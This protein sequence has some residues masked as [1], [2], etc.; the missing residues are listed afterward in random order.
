MAYFFFSLAPLFGMLLCWSAS[1]SSQR[2]SPWAGDNR[3]KLLPNLFWRPVLVLDMYDNRTT[4][5]YNFDVIP[6]CYKCQLRR[7]WVNF[8]YWTI[9]A[10]Q[11]DDLFHI[12]C[13]SLL[14]TLWLARSKSYSFWEIF[15]TYMP[16]LNLHVY[17]FS[18][19]I[20]TYT[21]IR[22]STFTYFGWN[23]QLKDHFEQF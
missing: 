2:M 9:F 10:C 23:S 5:G 7:I 22:V 15:P 1:L 12:S 16:Y 17:L 8:W 4:L 3:A 11:K 21:I 14:W 19:K 13:S 20:P 18:V 6:V